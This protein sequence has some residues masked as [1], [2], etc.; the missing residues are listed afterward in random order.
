MAKKNSY[1]LAG[2]LAFVGILLSTICWII[3]GLGG[4]IPFIA[5]IGSLAL[6]LAA[7][8]SAWGF[9]SSKKITWRYIY[10]ILVILAIFGWLIGSNI[11]HF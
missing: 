7:F 11:V 6:L 1:Y 5:W 9:V 4:N 10:F 2:L 3:E 8:I